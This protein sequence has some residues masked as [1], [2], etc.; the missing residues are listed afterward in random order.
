LDKLPEER[1]T[2]SRAALDSGYFSADNVEKVLE[3]QIEPYI[4][5]G[6]Q[7]PIP[8]NEL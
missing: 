5:K 8:V 7:S 4:A 2:V 3:Q 1:G 6:R